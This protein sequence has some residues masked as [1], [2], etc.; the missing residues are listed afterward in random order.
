MLSFARTCRFGFTLL[1]IC[2]TGSMLAAAQ[3]QFTTVIPHVGQRGTEI[4]LRL[5]G[6]RLTDAKEVLLHDEGI[7]ITSF[8]VPEDK[9]GREVRVKVR[10][11]P[12]CRPGAKRLVIRS[13]TGVSE[14]RNFHVTAL[15]VVDEAEPNSEFTT[16]QVI[17]K[18]VTVSGRIDNEDVDYFVIEAKKG[19]PISVEIEAIRLGKTFFDPYVAILNEARFELS[20]SDDHAL[21]WQDSINS[22]IAPE[23]GRYIVQVRDSAYGGNGASYYNL[24]VGSFPRPVGIVPMGGRPG[25]KVKVRFLGDPTGVMEQ[26]VTV[27]TEPHKEF[28]FFAEDGRGLAPSWNWFRIS[29][30]ENTIEAEPNNAREQATAF[31][32]PGAVNGVLEAP[33]DV[34]WFKFSMKKNQTLDVE[35]YG[36]R[37]RSSIDAVIRIYDSKGRQRA[38]NDDQRGQDSFQRFKAPEDD[39][40]F[41]QVSDHLGKGGPSYT[42]RVEINNV[43]PVLELTTN[44]F[45]RYVKPPI[46]VPQGRRYAVLMNA[47]RRDFGGE[48]SFEGIDLPQGVR[49]ESP[50]SWAKSG[51]IPVMFHADENVELTG[52]LAQVI[53]KWTDPNNKDRV[54]ASAAVQDHMLVRGQNNRAVWTESV[55]RIP[56]VVCKQTPFDVKI[57]PPKVPIVRGGRMNLKV[58]AEKAEGFDNDIRVLLLQNA[59]GVSS[60][61]SVSIKKGETEALIPLNASGNAPIMESMI[62]VRAYATVGDATVEICTPFAP[63][64]VEDKYVNLKFQQ[65]AV[66]Q[67]QDAAVLVDVEQ[68][69]DFEG[70]AEVVLSGLPAKATTEPMKITKETEELTFIVKTDPETPAGNHKSL[71]CTVKVI[72]NGEEIHHHIAG[73]RLRVDKPLPKPVAKAEPEKKEEPKP[74]AAPQPKPLSRLELLRKQREERLAEQAAGE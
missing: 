17:D 59:P 15:P 41:I 53:G 66:E 5:L 45:Q 25:E 52:S 1:A 23:D 19:E 74:K 12:D 6:N 30:L 43:T 31:T 20:T 58:V 14:L 65:A 72:E 71:F 57:V 35:V 28:G 70:E 11:A 3:P 10:I 54:V 39:E 64:R 18:N 2:L 50:S 21:V 33:G 47:S 42:Y 40:Y 26:E 62:A 22:I 46:P 34:D 48:I 24:H 32:A 36:R 49:I 73:G 63:L 60:S 56:V 9:K 37:L 51:T 68:F 27:P 67:G 7:E 29:E 38:A 44:E 4:E 61:R 8:E 13:E 69:T 55:D 16:P